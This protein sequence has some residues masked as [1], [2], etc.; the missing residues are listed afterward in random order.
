MWAVDGAKL[1]CGLPVCLASQVDCNFCFGLSNSVIPAQQE[2]LSGEVGGRVL[3]AG[4]ASGV[5]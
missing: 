1:S 2:S 3:W 4:K 5:G